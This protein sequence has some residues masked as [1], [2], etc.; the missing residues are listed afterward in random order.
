[1]DKRCCSVER[2]NHIDRKSMRG[3]NIA[4]E[5]LL[6]MPNIEELE[7]ER[8]IKFEAIC[9]LIA[10]DLGLGEFHTLG[11]SD[12]ALVKAEADEATERWMEHAD[13]AT[14]PKTNLQKLLAE[15]FKLVG[16]ILDMLDDQ[17]SEE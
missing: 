7:K 9:A 2:F 8:V 10:D 17:E 14:P 5:A 16:R 11:E 12:R 13:M 3:E 1:M 6:P 4:P 15:H